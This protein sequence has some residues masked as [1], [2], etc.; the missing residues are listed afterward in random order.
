MT[1]QEQKERGDK[2][3]IGNYGRY[4]VALDRG[5]G[6]EVWDVEGRRYLDFLAGIAVCNLGHCHPAVVSAIKEQADKLIHVSNLY[7]IEAQTQLSELLVANSFADRAFYCNSGAEA[8][9]AAIKLARIASPEGKGTIISLSE[10]FH[11]R[12]LATITATGQP[13]FGQ[14]FEPLPPGFVTAP[15]GDLEALEAAIDAT[16]CAIICEPLQGEGGVRPLEQEYLQGI[17]SL[18]DKYDLLLIFDEVQT[19]IG[20]SGKLF[21]YQQFG[22]EPDIISLAKGLGSGVP[23]GAILARGEVAKAFVPG[24]HG[25]TFGGNPLVCA[26]ALATIKTIATDDFLEEVE[27]KARYLSSLLEKLVQDYPQT[28]SAERGMGLLRGLVMTKEAAGRGS[29]IV[30][31]LFERGYL[32]NFAGGVALRFAPPLVVSPEQC[33]ELIAEIRVVLQDGEFK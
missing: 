10:S 27:D 28:F 21:A 12:T 1:N 6:C 13:K 16:T 25:S 23:I 9:E 5:R 17:R 29:E 32:M 33:D 11:G 19:G 2:V 15:Y 4:P 31:S 14:G 24:S 30:N 7:Y 8:N 18:C 26:A 22:V 3:L 20:R